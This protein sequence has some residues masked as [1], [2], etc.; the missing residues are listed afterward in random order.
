[1]RLISSP[2][3]AACNLALVA[4]AA[5]AA[6]A[7]RPHYGGALHVEIRQSF[8]TPDPPTTG[9]GMPDLARGFAITSWEAGRRAV[10]AA[11][12]SAPGGRPFLD[13]VEIEMARP[14]R[15]QSIDLEL[16]K[17]DLVELG[18][19]ELRR[20][21]AGRKVWSSAP[22]RLVALVFSARV[23][24]ARIREA[25][26]LAVDRAAIHNVLLQRQGEVSAALLP[27][28]LSGYA[29]LFPTAVDSA[30]ARTLLAGLPA[31]VRA[32][33]L[34]VEDAAERPIAERIALNARDAGLTV[35]VVS[36]AAG[37][38]VRL[39][40]VRIG[41]L[42]PALALAGLALSLGLSEPPRAD[43][44]GALY[45]AE[46]ALLEGFRVIPLFHLPDAYGV[47]PRVKGRPG[48]TPLGEWRFE[49]LWVEGG[50]P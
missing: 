31:A 25:L 12:E 22:V 45:S 10:Y 20:Q 38:D 19:S 49:N 9:Y 8:E 15:D 36:Q 7:T 37:A 4:L 18:P 24:D 30:R 42:D 29:F 43:T 40:E 21:P 48:I 16:G 33:S 44:P 28:W 1:M 5:T 2:W 3:F 23:E 50:R 47:N 46:R 32:I 27:Q 11:D 41:S 26:A 6:A 17:T 14:L 34:G 39:V 35:S 13:S